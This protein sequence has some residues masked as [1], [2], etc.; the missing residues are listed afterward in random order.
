MKLIQAIESIFDHEDDNTIWIDS[1]NEITLDSLV[2]IA[3][4]KDSG[5][6]PPDAQHYSYFLEVFL[7]KEIVADI[8]GGSIINKNQLELITERV[9]QY[10]I[11]DA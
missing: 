3:P 8:T 6:P 5:G 2:V 7:I 10:A 1:I 9:I 4:E 11:N